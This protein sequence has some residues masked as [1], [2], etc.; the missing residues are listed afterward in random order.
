MGLILDL[1]AKIL[2]SV[3]RGLKPLMEAYEQIKDP[4]RLGEGSAADYIRVHPTVGQ[5]FAYWVANALYNT[6]D[7]EAESKGSLLRIAYAVNPSR[8]PIGMWDIKQVLLQG[9]NPLS[10]DYMF[11]SKDPAEILR[12]FV[13]QGQME[14]FLNE[15]V[16]K[17]KDPQGKETE[18]QL[19]FLPTS[20]LYP[21]DKA[22]ASIARKVREN[23]IDAVKSSVYEYR[24]G[25][26]TAPA[27]FD[28]ISGEG[29]YLGFGRIQGQPSGD[30]N[31]TGAVSKIWV[32][33][34]AIEVYGDL[35]G[36]I[37]YTNSEEDIRVESLNE[38]F[39]FTSGK[40][41][42]KYEEGYYL[43]C[44]LSPLRFYSGNSL[45]SAHKIETADVM[46]DITKRL[47]EVDNN[48]S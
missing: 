40:E 29:F 46:V 41:S 12:R 2:D 17:T 43:K 24:E 5:S 25:D 9:K 13:Q 19:F 47:E 35:A 30:W 16:R 14:R 31:D 8:D 33:G 27:R 26:K 20:N 28:H 37:I 22:V 3:D 42:M 48:L 45:K 38:L 15:E 7:K 18:G 6:R 23:S 4:S 1:E 21:F 39:K 34:V 11:G 10:T 36:P 44:M 32:P